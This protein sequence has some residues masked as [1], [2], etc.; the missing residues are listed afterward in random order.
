M[1]EVPKGWIIRY[2][3]ANTASM[4]FIIVYLHIIRT[5]PPKRM[6]IKKKRNVLW[7]L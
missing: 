2:T 6:G 4:F 7:K 3:H 5:I 1:R